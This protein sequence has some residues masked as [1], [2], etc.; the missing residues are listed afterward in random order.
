MLSVLLSALCPPVPLKCLTFWRYTNQIII[1][2]IIMWNEASTR[3]RL[4]ISD[5]KL[6]CMLHYKLGDT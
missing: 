2:I 1:I 3:C 6:D 4:N 5:E